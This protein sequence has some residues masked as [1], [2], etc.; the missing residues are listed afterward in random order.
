MIGREL[1]SDRV[2]VKDTKLHCFFFFYVLALRFKVEGSF[3][4]HILTYSH[5]SLPII[6]DIIGS[7]M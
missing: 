4:R 6:Q 3:I 7:E 1:L 5:N 2:D